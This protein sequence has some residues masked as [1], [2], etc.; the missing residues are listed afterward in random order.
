ML[1]KLLRQLTIRTKFYL[2]CGFSTLGY[3]FCG[4]FAARGASVE[5]FLGSGA[6]F[7]MLNCLALGT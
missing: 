2:L 7:V 4:A 1:R 6:A 3:A 5:V